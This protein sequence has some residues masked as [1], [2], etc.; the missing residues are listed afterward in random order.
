MLI[1]RW[2][3]RK[4]IIWKCLYTATRIAWNSM[5]QVRRLWI[6]FSFSSK[7]LRIL[8]RFSGWMGVTGQ[9]LANATNCTVIMVDY[10][11]ISSCS[12]SRSAEEIV[13]SIGL[14]LAELI[15]RLNLDTDK[16]ELI[17][18]SLGAH[19]AGIAGA[20]LNGEIA[21]ITGLWRFSVL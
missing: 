17:G 4:A 15:K 10:R 6:F 2:T 7:I 12:Y 16:I 9:A 3:S 5:E 8:F 21:R 19:I 20:E 13:P 11:N 1:K 14:Y 18:H